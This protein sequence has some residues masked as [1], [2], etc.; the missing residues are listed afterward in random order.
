MGGMNILE[1]KICS[2]HRNMQNPGIGIPGGIAVWCCVG[3]L[4]ED[5]ELRW[6]KEV[7]WSKCELGKS[8]F[9]T[10]KYIVRK[11][12]YLSLECDLVV[13]TGYS[14]R[15]C[16]L[17]VLVTYVTLADLDMKYVCWYVIITTY[18]R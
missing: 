2:F 13:T 15:T 6:P 11:L 14:E 16:T 17:L 9:C 18:S 12:V 7:G 10:N 8:R 5:T 1:G 4:V 3:K